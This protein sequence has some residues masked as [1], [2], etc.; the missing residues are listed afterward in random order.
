MLNI[1]DILFRLDHLMLLLL[2]QQVQ[3][4]LIAAQEAITEAQ[5]GIL[6]LTQ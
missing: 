1:P 6:H 2:A 5:E 4:V 3:Q